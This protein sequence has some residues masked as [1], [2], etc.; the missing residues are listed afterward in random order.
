LQIHFEQLSPSLVHF[1]SSCIYGYKNEVNKKPTEVG[2][3]I[4]VI[5]ILLERNC[6]AVDSNFA[7]VV[8]GVT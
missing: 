3:C 6:R 4:V 8:S 2:F 5:P 7:Q 1:Y